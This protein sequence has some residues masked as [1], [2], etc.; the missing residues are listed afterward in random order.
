VVQPQKIR[1]DWN[2]PVIVAASGPSLSKSVA[3]KCRMARFNGWRVLAVNDAYRLMPWADILY[4]C[5]A[6]W[7]KQH[8]GAPG[9]T[10]GQRWSTHEGETPNETNYKGDL[11]EAWRINYARGRA[12]T[13]FST[14]PAFLYY[15]CNSGFQAIN[16]AVLKG[17]TRIVLV[18]Y[19]MRRVDGAAHFFGEHPNGLCATTD[20]RK[21]LPNFRDAAQHCAVPIVNATPGSALDCWPM[22]NL[23]D[24]LAERTD[25]LLY[26]DR[27]DAHAGGYRDSA[28]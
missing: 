1:P 28:A 22:V 24:A 19:D 23:D 2:C 6:E 3:Q 20:Y 27:P 9:L 8:N 14:N 5:D 10:F 4:A 26:R 11:P 25:G 17:A 12:G 7:W 13:V 21:F 18:G 15:G 16:L